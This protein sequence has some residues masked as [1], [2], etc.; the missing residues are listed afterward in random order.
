MRK[1][2]GEVP[3]RGIK[4]SEEEGEREMKRLKRRKETREKRAVQRWT[5]S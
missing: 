3:N 5:G 2:K 4:K 1:T